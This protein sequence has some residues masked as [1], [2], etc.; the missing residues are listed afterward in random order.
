MIDFEFH[1]PTT[2]AEAFDLL[3]QYG[4]DARVIAGGTAL[5]LQM[6]QRFAQPGH[7]IGLRKIPG[8]NS[9]AIE[10]TES[11]GDTGS[12]CI[13][14]L[15]TQRSIESSEIIGQKL[16]LVT[17]TFRRVATPR[18]RSM[19]TIGGGLVHGDPNQD[20]PPTLI[21]LGTS[22]VLTSSQGRRVVPV[23]DLFL[24]YFETDLRPGEILTSVVVPQA[25]P[26]SGA[27]YLKFLPRTADDY[28]TVSVAAVVTA[29]EDNVCRDVRIVLGSVGVTP[30]HASDAEDSLRG[31]PLNEENIRAC[32]AMISGLV[33]PLDDYRGSAEYKREMAQVFTRR[34]IQQAMS[35][36]SREKNR[37]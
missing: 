11:N 32:A 2:L 12:V 8:L 7:V 15:C 19:A 24:D 4:D 9:I 17:E 37:D 30:V 34:A 31:Q 28:A 10:T 1:S 18:I 27:A 26:G 6:K 35:A 13:G 21:A 22:A 23:E 33:D 5:V 25:P 14:A 16:P 29:G 20:P 36:L 3:E